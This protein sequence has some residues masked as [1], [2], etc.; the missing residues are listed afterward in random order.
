M[1]ERADLGRKVFVARPGSPDP[2]FILGWLTRVKLPEFQL[3]E[4]KTR[5]VMLGTRHSWDGAK[6]ECTKSRNFFGNWEAR[7]ASFM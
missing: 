7:E 4:M 5:G 1:L 6:F 3:R 2:V